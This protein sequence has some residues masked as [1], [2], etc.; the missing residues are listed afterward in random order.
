[1]S[2]DN[3]YSVSGFPKEHDRLINSSAFTG[4][5]LVQSHQERRRTTGS[6]CC[7]LVSV[8]TIL[9]SI[10]AVTGQVTQY[11]SL[12]LWI[13]STTSAQK[14]TGEWKPTVD[15]YFVVSFASLSFVIAFGL[16]LLCSDFIC[17]NY[18]VK[19]DWNYRR[20]MLLVGSF[21]GVSAIFIVFSSSG[22]R[23]PPYLQAI[24]GNFSVP[25]T[26]ILRFLFLKKIP[27][28]RKLLSAIAVVLGLFI[29]LIPTF[30]SQIDSEGKSH[31]GGATGVG[32]V[33]WPL[34]FMLG[35]AIGATAFVVEEK[36]VKMQG[37]GHTQVGL[38][39]VLFWTS[40]AQFLVVVL[41]F[42]ADVIPGF[43]YTNNIH[44]F[45]QNWMFGVQCV[46]GGAGC[47]WT[48][49]VLTAVFIAGYI[50]TV[51]GCALLLRYSEGATLLAIVTSLCTPLGFIFWMLFREK[52]FGWHPY[53]QTSSW[54]SI[55]ALIIMI[56]AAFIYNTGM[57]ERE[58]E[59]VT[60]TTDP[61]R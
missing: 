6:S 59:E 35:F 27:T 23:T 57:P 58:R 19:T 44:E 31:L 55:T 22:N 50:M 38:I 16:V 25:V 52:P 60:P 46:F 29:C 34:A 24:L 17:R 41:L 45:I 53:F 8:A 40:L 26:L 37:S 21:Q 51:C 36:V 3:N 12:P 61:E 5:Q 15:G 43:G 9:F 30:S 4:D 56:P 49:G 18:L 39:S 7:S 48:P 42:W 11:V 2:V 14:Q 54:F 47:S 10:V 13:D 1:M 20:L 33:L 28:R 32:R